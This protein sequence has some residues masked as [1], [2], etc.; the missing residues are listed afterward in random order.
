[1]GKLGASQ[2]GLDFLHNTI[3][4]NRGLFLA[5]EYEILKERSTRKPTRGLNISQAF[6]M[7]SHTVCLAAVGE[8]NHP[9]RILQLSSLFILSSLDTHVGEGNHPLRILQHF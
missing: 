1:L 5:K 9:L 7:P 4:E 6:E 2:I 8:G 3:C